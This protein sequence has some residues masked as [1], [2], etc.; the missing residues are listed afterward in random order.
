MA[1]RTRPRR[2]RSARFTLAALLVIPLISLVA[3][4]AF[5]ASLTIGP[6]LTERTNTQLIHQGNQ[7]SVGL[8]EAV[9]LEREQSY[10]WLTT[11]RR[12][13]QAPLLADRKRTSA[14]VVQYRALAVSERTLEPAQAVTAQSALVAALGRLP[15]IRS[16]VDAGRLSPIDAFEAYSA[17]VDAQFAY[18]GVDTSQDVQ[19]F[20]QTNGSVYAARA[21][22]LI[23]REV[24]LVAA[25]QITHGYLN[26]AARQLFATSVAEQRQLISVALQLFSGPERTQYARLY[27]SPAHQQLATLENKIS[28]SVGSRGRLPVSLKAW[29]AASGVFLADMQKAE[30]AQAAPLA[31]LEASSSDSLLLRALLAGGLGLVAVVASILLTIWFGRRLTRELTGLHESAE[32]IASERLPGIVTRLRAGDDVDVEAESPPPAPGKITE[33][34]KVAQSFATVQR[35][36]VEAA[37][38]QANL[39][40]GV[41]QVF[42]N[43]SLRNQSLLHRQLSM[44]DS[45]ERATSDPAAL[46]ELF[47]LDHLTTRMRRHAEGLIIL[48]GSTPGRGWRDPVPVVD[49]LRAAVAEVED[50]VRVDVVSE[51]RDSVVGPAVNDVIHLV[52]ELIE[53]ATSFSPPNTQVEVR[54]DSVG[55]GFAVEVEDRGLGLTQAELAEINTRLASPPEFDLANSDQL[56]LFVVGQLAARHGIRVSLRESPYGGIRAIALMPHSIIVSAAEPGGPSAAGYGRPPA[57]EPAFEPD[58]GPLRWTEPTANRARASAFSLTGRH[59]LPSEPPAAEARPGSADASPAEAGPERTHLGLPMRVR[60]ASIVPQLRTDAPEPPDDPD[61]PGLEL[62]SP[63]HARSLM[64]ALQ[65]GWQQGRADDLAEPDFPADDPHDW[66]GQAQGS[67]AYPSDGEATR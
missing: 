58:T 20:R 22:E 60:Q 24:G 21:A 61:R 62:R 43:L 50:Y 46:E 64:A 49:V 39:R 40:K 27:A 51:S 33:I 66:P 45:M 15:G 25:A 41:N 30:A 36:A 7:V 2:T 4:W 31:Q 52:A 37:V 55:S 48:S 65:E 34:A 26:S 47:R 29:Q 38:G 67:A 56:G 16:A 19:L 14:L 5:A 54:A 44:L 1:V 8:L 57:P 23:G 6:A 53:N 17:I 10:I 63:D 9:S 42:L 13:P 3:L 12:G 18:Y 11:G 59:K 32:S 28:G 35:T